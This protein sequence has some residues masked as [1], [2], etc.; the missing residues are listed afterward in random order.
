[1]IAIRNTLE[2][3]RKKSDDLQEDC[4]SAADSLAATISS[5]I[6]RPREYPIVLMDNY[7]EW[8]HL[9]EQAL[10]RTASDPLMKEKINTII[11]P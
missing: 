11:R 9:C 2:I 1:M 6:V 7:Y 5:L 8:K 3:S 10:Q 4:S